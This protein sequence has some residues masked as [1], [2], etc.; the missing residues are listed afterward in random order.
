[1]GGSSGL[2]I[3]EWETCMN[4]VEGR[5]LRLAE[6]DEALDILDG[7]DELPNGGIVARFR[8]GSVW[9]P[10]ELG[11][12]LRELVGKKASVLHLCGYHVRCL[13]EG[14]SK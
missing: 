1:M 5:L 10:E 8:F 14:G 4:E 7:I 6:L 12:K 11:S 3:A 2:C 13:D 9:L